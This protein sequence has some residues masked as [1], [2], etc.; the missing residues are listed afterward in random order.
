M[1]I[2]LGRG[3]GIPPGDLLNEMDR[4]M[5]LEKADHPITTFKVIIRPAKGD[6]IRCRE[7]RNGRDHFEG[8]A[9]KA[10]GISRLRRSGRDRGK[11]ADYQQRKKKDSFH[12][13]GLSSMPPG[14]PGGSRGQAAHYVF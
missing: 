14:C 4:L 1:I 7:V 12:H 8:I 3:L 11:Q 13:V 10:D 5:R 2:R 9:R 6:R